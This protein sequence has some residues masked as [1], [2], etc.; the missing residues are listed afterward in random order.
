MRATTMAADGQNQRF[1]PTRHPEGG[2]PRLDLRRGCWDF[3]A[4]GMVD[5]NGKYIPNEQI[6]FLANYTNKTSS[7]SVNASTVGC[8]ISFNGSYLAMSFNSTSALYGSVNMFL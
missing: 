2:N 8:N 5:G 4:A 6:Y 1:C 3:S 7:L